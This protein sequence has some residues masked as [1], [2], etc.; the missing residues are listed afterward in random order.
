[1][2]TRP[3]LQVNESDFRFLNGGWQALAGRYEGGDEATDRWLDALTLAYSGA[4]RHYHNLHHVAEMLRL[5]E[6]F[7]S[8]AADYAAVRFAAW[9]HDAVYDTR[10]NTNEE[11]SAALA[12]RALVE[13]KVPPP[14]IN[15]TRRLILATKRH[16]AQDDLPDAGLF[17]DADL[18]ILG[19]ADE[20][21]LA[22]SE[23]IRRE[24]SWV[25]D[26]AYREGRIK[27][28]DSFLGRERLY[29]TV[30]L[31][32]RFEARARSNVLNEIRTL[33]S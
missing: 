14:V 23:A 17:L 21:Y 2:S 29:F 3:D 13:L 32:E 9:F 15:L 26:A 8:D 25:P 7:E 12:E 31:S 10:S 5:L 4:G 6:Q 28:L 30:P 19:A 18:A 20:T 33:S 27:V 11:E 16:E 22:Y 24:Y 1:M